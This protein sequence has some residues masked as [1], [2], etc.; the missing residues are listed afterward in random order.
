M[1]Q[2]NP[3]RVASEELRQ[4]LERD[5]VRAGGFVKHDDTDAVDGSLLW[6]A[7]PFGVV[8]VDDVRFVRTVERIEAEL[9]VPAGGVRRYLGDTFYGGGEWVILTAW[10]GW[11][12]QAL[13][14]RDEA[15]EC[16]DWIESTATAALELPEQVTDRP[17]SPDHVGEWVRRWG[18]PATPLLWSHAMYLVL[19]DALG[20]R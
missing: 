19:V 17:L 13:G 10:L 20:L 16:L 1:V 14:R 3:F 9:K 7:L 2:G 4:I 18:P 12:R 11:G 6:L 8:R 5:F 15:L